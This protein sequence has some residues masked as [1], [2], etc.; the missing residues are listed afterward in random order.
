MNLYPFCEFENEID[1]GQDKGQN[2]AESP[3]TLVFQ[4]SPWINRAIM[5]FQL[6][7]REYCQRYREYEP[8]DCDERHAV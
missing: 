3:E 1:K 6:L 2:K 7:Y 5:L 8:C 4:G